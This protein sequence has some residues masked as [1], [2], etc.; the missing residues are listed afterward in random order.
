MKLFTIKRDARPHRFLYL[1]IFFLFGLFFLFVPA[2]PQAI[3]INHNHT[4]ISEVPVYWIEQAK[5][6]FKIS[7]G[8]TSHGSQIISGMQ[9]LSAQNSLFAFNADG[10]NGAL[11]LHDATPAGDLGNPNRTEWANRTRTLLSNPS[12]DRNLIMWSWCGQ[13][14]S[15]NQ[16]DIDTY[17]TLMNQLEQEFPGVTF[18][19]MTGHLDGTGE[20]G[21]LHVRNEQIR[22]YCRVNNKIL[23]DFADIESYDPDGNYFLDKG[24][25][26]G[27][28]YWDNSVSKNWALEWCSA[29]PGECS[30]CSCAHSQS[31]NCDLKGRAFWWMM[32]RAAG[33]DGLTA[34]SP[35]IH[36]NKTRLTFGG[37]SQNNPTSSQ[38]FTVTNEGLG[39]LIWTAAP[40]ELWISV[41]PQTGTETGIVTVSVD[42]NGLPQGTHTGSVFISD[43]GASNSPQTVNIT[44]NIYDQGQDTAPFGCLDTPSEGLTVSGSIAVTGWALD[45]VEVSRIEIKRD[46]DAEDIPEAIGSDGLVHIGYAF[47]VKGSRSDIETLYTDYPHNDRAGWGYMLLTFGL[48]R[49]GNGHF[50]LHAFAEDTTGNRAPLGTKNIVCNNL[51][52]KEPFGAID[53]PAPGGIVSG[54]AYIN[55]GWA[56]TPPGQ[57][58]KFIPY[59]GSTVYWSIDS[60]IRG[61]VNYGDY[62]SDI[63]GAFPLC[64]NCG[65]AGGHLYIDTTQ[66]ENGIHMIGWLVYD[67]EGNGDGIGSRFFEIRN[68]G[69]AAAE[70]R[71]EERMKYSNTFADHLKL[72]VPGSKVIEIEELERIKIQFETEGGTRIIG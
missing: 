27:C 29:H 72:S 2:F 52:R 65:S 21:N 37:I 23:F 59:T 66:F 24:A 60:V 19:Y 33:W 44:L 35:L 3:V 7:Y 39:T 4:D 13:V 9:V 48:P 36:T 51:N 63:A 38:T 16:G 14:S 68:S 40:S 17:L 1:G 45:D 62:R 15:A 18:I 71:I 11:S 54:T 55:F 46:P 41:T 49:K 12:C 10:T 53:T 31:L 58:N 25:N 50:K 56:L 64:L 69:A 34:D 47:I 8:H 22:N 67:N 43:P 28:Y 32:A 61:T 20:S 5:S 57:T 26:D 42:P 70:T 6:L 30:S